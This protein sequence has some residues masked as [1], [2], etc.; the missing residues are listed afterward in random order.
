MLTI[1]TGSGTNYG[2][3]YTAISLLST[4]ASYNLTMIPYILIRGWKHPRD[5]VTSVFD[6]SGGG[7]ITINGNTIASTSYNGSGSSSGITKGVDTYSLFGITTGS[8]LISLINSVQF[9]SSG[10]WGIT[11][12]YQF[13][14]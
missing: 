1:T 6:G 11:V 7:S 14:Q 8:L 9:V 13:Y 5:S 10:Y 4:N 12:Y 2:T 3:T